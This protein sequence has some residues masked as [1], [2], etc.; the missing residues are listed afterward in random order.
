MATINARIDDDIKN[1]ADEV[2][3]LLNISQT[4]AIAAFYQYVAE[5]KKLPFVITSVV[6]TPHDLLRE[7]SD[8]LA[9]ALAVIS[10]LQAW[11]EQ[12]DGIEKAKL[13]EYYRRLDAL[14]RC[15]KDKISLIPDN[16]DA[17]LA[18]NAF[19]KALSILVDT[20]NFGYGY[21]KV[22]F[23]TLEQTSFAFAVHEFESK[24]A[25]LVHCVRKGELE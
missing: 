24:V 18:L 9:E 4:Q 25:G 23:S 6:K 10:N 3:K 7:S 15:A 17:E 20:R 14:Y 11:T 16:R 1:Q 21:E 8:M 2:L 5:Q 13:M 19:N 22:T 12:P